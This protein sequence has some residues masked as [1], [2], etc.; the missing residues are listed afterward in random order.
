MD[1][2]EVQT[3][4]T[5]EARHHE[6]DKLLQKEE[7]GLAPDYVRLTKLKREKLRLKDQIAELV[8]H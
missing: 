5:L 7:Q 6:L 3:M 2:D 1:N 8:H 4:S